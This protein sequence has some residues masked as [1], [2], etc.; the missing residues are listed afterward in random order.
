[1]VADLEEMNDIS[2]AETTNITK[3]SNH[4]TVVHKTNTPLAQ[5]TTNTW[6]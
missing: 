1:M 3:K 2:E 5:I 6:Q 4:I